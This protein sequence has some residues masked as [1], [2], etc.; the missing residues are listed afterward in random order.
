MFLKNRHY[1]QLSLI[2]LLF[3]LWGFAHS[4][5]DVLNKHFQE[6]LDISKARTGW[7][8]F[9]VYGSYFTVALP[10]GWFIQKFGYKKGILLGLWIFGAGALAF[11]PAE[12][13]GSFA[14]Y[15]TALAIIGT[16]LTFLETAANPYITML[17]SAETAAS[18][19]NL[20]QAF[21]G[22][23]WIIGP[24]AGGLLVFKADGSSGE[25]GPAYLMLAVIVLSFSVFIHKTPFQKITEPDSEA[26]SESQKPT[27]YTPFWF[28]WVALFL[29]VG[30][31]TGVN[32]FFIH[33]VTE[34]DTALS[35]R[36]AVWLL[37]FGAMGLFM[38]GRI[39][40]S[41]LMTR[42]NAYAIFLC[43]A[44]ISVV[45]SGFLPIMEG[46][47][48]VVV[49]VS[50]YFFKSIMFPTIFSFSLEHSR[51]QKSKASS[52]LIM[53]IIGGALTPPLMG[54]LGEQKMSDGFLIPFI[55]YIFIAVYAIWIYRFYLKMSHGK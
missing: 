11:I 31:Q 19:L 15:L 14:F 16:G 38:L 44:L 20:A 24:L 39:S 17:G 43:F 34:S 27:L 2:V 50:L 51:A 12:Y 47:Y 3:F 42:Y 13:I 28:G 10:A 45:I 26:V 48:S 33:Y 37:S 53:A 6:I 54:Y 22:L 32:S 49:I 55:C 36:D 40:G 35:S 30:A 52:Y 8:Q 4:I 18:R 21:N 1:I 29:Y 41:I 9:V 25:I 46:P 5:L 7:V 23:G